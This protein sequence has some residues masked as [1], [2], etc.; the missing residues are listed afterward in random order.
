MLRRGFLFFLFCSVVFLNCFPARRLTPPQQV[1]PERVLGDLRLNEGDLHSAALSLEFKFSGKGRRFSTQAEVFYQQPEAFTVYFKSNSYL[2]VFKSVIRN[3]SVFFYLPERNEYYLDSYERFS[4]TKG[5]EWGIGLKD[6]LNLIVGKNGLEK[7][8]LRFVKSEKN[9]LVFVSE[10][11]FW[12]RKFWV[13]Q[14]K[15]Q[16]TK[17][18][19]TGKNNGQILRIDYKNYKDYE[20]RKLPSFLQIKIPSERE[21]LK[22]RFKK[23]KINLPISEK[24]FRLTIP[25]DAQR[26]WLKEKD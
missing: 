11:E 18:E 4:E 25:Q 15:K 2:N 1:D 14:R 17:S 5:W 10:D 24:R 20:G 19:W 16:L 21:T 13:D 23:R 9:D 26:V 22:V 8:P 7:A 12:E 6:F 3:D